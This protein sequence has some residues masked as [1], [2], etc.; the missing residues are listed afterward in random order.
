MMNFLI[1]NYCVMADEMGGGCSQ[2]EIGCFQNHLQSSWGITRQLAAERTWASLRHR[3]ASQGDPDAGTT[4]Q[5]D[6]QY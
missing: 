5:K 2:S 3:M 1:Y 4:A 6:Q